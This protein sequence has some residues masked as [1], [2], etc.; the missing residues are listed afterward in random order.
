M[1]GKRGAEGARCLDGPSRR[2]LIHSTRMLHPVHPSFPSFQ[3]LD[4]VSSR[5]WGAKRG[6]LIS[7]P[8]PLEVRKCVGEVGDIRIGSAVRVLC[9]CSASSPR[10]PSELSDSHEG[11]DVEKHPLHRGLNGGG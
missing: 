2:S 6:Y 11:K 4:V 9:E 8:T 1:G 3:P 10:T 5:R 7:I